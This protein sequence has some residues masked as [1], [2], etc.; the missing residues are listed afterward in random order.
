MRRTITEPN[1][2]YMNSAFAITRADDAPR[3]LSR[4]A[5]NRVDDDQQPDGLHVPFPAF[6]DL[7]PLA[8]GL[9]ISEIGGRRR[10][11]RRRLLAR[12]RRSVYAS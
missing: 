3:G 11:R 1:N 5:A 8:A 7:Y 10:R 6:P 4:P 9:L 2:R 12:R